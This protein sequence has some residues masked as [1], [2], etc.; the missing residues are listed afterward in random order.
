MTSIA[1]TARE[2]IRTDPALA[3][4]IARLM[5]SRH[6]G[7]LTVRQRDAL[8]FIRT[9]HGEHGVTPTFDEIRLGMGL[10]S[11]S[12]IKR[13][14]DALVERGFVSRLANRARSIV[15]REVAE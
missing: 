15:L 8:D 11:K 1:E 7:G 14:V 3:A 5:A 13:L 4:E 12:D 2:L 9:Y 6:V 10:K